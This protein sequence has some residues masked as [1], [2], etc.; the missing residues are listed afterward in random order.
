M[1]RKT[2][3]KLA[4]CQLFAGLFCLVFVIAHA[5]LDA[6]HNG[7]KYIGCLSCHQMTSTY[8]KLLPPLHH[9]PLDGDFDD[10]VANGVCWSCH[11]DSTPLVCQECHT[12]SSAPLVL[13]HSSLTTGD[14][15]HGSWT[16]ECWVCHNQHMQEQNR[17]NGS[18]YGKYIRRSINLKNIK[19]GS[20]NPL[21]GKVLPNQPYIKSVIFK[22]STGANSFADGDATINGICEVCHTA[23]SHSRNNDTLGG[24]KHFQAYVCTEC[25]D[26]TTG[27]KPGWPDHDQ[28]VEK[29]AF[30]TTCHATSVFA[31]HQVNETDSTTCKRCHQTNNNYEFTG[32]LPTVYLKDRLTKHIGKGKL[33]FPATAPARCD[34][35]HH[36]QFTEHVTDTGHNRLHDKVVLGYDSDNDG[37]GDQVLACDA[38][39]FP[40]AIQEHVTRRNFT[41]SVCHDRTG[42]GMAEVAAISTTIT[43]GMAGTKIFCDDCH[44]DDHFLTEPGTSLVKEH[45]HTPY[46]KAGDCSKCHVVGPG[47][48]G[49]HRPPCWHCHA[50]GKPGD[51]QRA[52]VNSHDQGPAI[53]ADAVQDFRICFSCHLDG[54]QGFVAGTTPLATPMHGLP[55][56]APNYSDVY[57]PY[58]YYRDSNGQWQTP[59]PLMPNYYDPYIP[60]NLEGDL[61]KWLQYP[62]FRTLNYLGPQKALSHLYE[63]YLSPPDP[64]VRVWASGLTFPLPNNNYA[65]RYQVEISYQKQDYPTV[66]I[67]MGG[68]FEIPSF[69]GTGTIGKPT[70][71]GSVNVNLN[72]EPVPTGAQWRLDGGPWRNSGDS[73]A[74][75]TDRE[76]H[77]VEF[78]PL[79]GKAEPAPVLVTVT[80]GQSAALNE[81]DTTYIDCPENPQLT[82][83]RISGDT[84][85]TFAWTSPEQEE[86]FMITGW[87]SGPVECELW[88]KSGNELVEA[89]GF[90]VNTTASGDSCRLLKTGITPAG[91]YDLLLRVNGSSCFRN[92]IDQPL[93]VTVTAAGVPSPFGQAGGKITQPFLN[94]LALPTT[95]IQ[96]FLHLTGNLYVYLDTTGTLRTF[97]IDNQGTVVP[98]IPTADLWNNAT[99]IKM[100]R[101][102]DTLIAVTYRIANTSI[103]P[104]LYEN[105][106]MSVGIEQNGAVIYKKQDYLFHNSANGHSLQPQIFPHHDN[107]SLFIVTWFGS[108]FNGLLTVQINQSGVITELDRD[109][110]TLPD[111]SVNWRGNIAHVAGDTYAYAMAQDI[112]IFQVGADGTITIPNTPGSTY[113]YAADASYA[114]MIRV[115]GDIFAVAYSR[116]PSGINEGVLETISISDS[117]VISPTINTYLF[118]PCSAVNTQLIPIS[119][120]VI[121]VYYHE[122]GSCDGQGGVNLKTIEITDDG[123]IR[124]PPLDGMELPGGGY[125][126][127][128]RLLQVEGDIFAFLLHNDQSQGVTFNGIKTYTISR[129]RDADGID[130]SADNCPNQGN[131]GQA[132]SDSDGVGDGCDICAGVADTDTDG[133]GIWDCTD[134]CPSDPANDADGDGICADVDHCPD[135]PANDGDNDGLCAGSGFQGSKTGDRDNCPTA[136]NPGQADEDCDGTGDACSSAPVY[137]PPGT[138]AATAL[139][140]TETTITWK[141]MFDGE[142]GYRIER[143]AESCSANTLGF[144]PLVTIYRHDSFSSGIDNT[145]WNQGAALQTA[146]DYTPPILVADASGSAEISWE[147]GAAKLHTKAVN[148]GDT[149]YNYSYISPK[150][151][152]GV[153]GD[154]DFDVQIDF[155]LPNGVINATQYHTY[156]RLQ[157]DF[158]NTDD[159]GNV[160]YIERKADGIGLA[161]TVNG[162]TEGGSYA[163]NDY[164]GTIRLVRKNRVLSGYVW[165]GSKWL[166]IHTHS[167]A[168]TAD[169]VPTW[170]S[171]IH[172]ARRNEPAGQDITALIDNFRY[173]EV[174]TS[175]PPVA[176]LSLAFDEA[177]WQGT[178]G[179]VKDA[180]TDGNHG[181]AY[182]D[183]TTVLDE[184]RGRVGSFDWS[185][186]T[187]DYV[188]IPGNGT[189]KDLTSTSFTF[190]AWAK[191]ADVP[192]KTQDAPP[193]NDWIYAVMTRSYPPD[194]LT[195][196]HDKKFT[197]YV[198]DTGWGQVR[199][200][201]PTQ[202]EPGSWHHLAGVVDDTA[203]TI[204]LYVDGRMRAT[205]S[206]VGKTLYNN[207]GTSP[208]LVGISNPG[209]PDWIFPFKGR[210]DDVRIFN[211]AL[212]TD[213]VTALSEDNPTFR[214]SGLAAGTT[215]CY[216]VYPVKKDS[217][218]GW[219]K[220]ASTFEVTT[221]SLAEA[222]ATTAGTATAVAIN[223]AATLHVT[224]PYASDAN[225]DNTYTV[226]YKQS[227][228]GTWTTRVADAPHAAS[229]FAVNITG[230]TAGARY[231][232]R[233]TYLDPD[234][235]NGSAQQTLTGLVAAPGI[236]C[237]QILDNGGST[238]NGVYSIDPDG[239][240]GNAPFQAYCDMTGDGGGWTLAMK[241]DGS[242]NTFQYASS[243][244]TN[245]A[246]LNPGSPGFDTTEAKLAS[247]S[248][249]PFTQIRLGMRH[250]ANELDDVDWITI[251][252][253]AASLTSLFQPGAYIATT[254]GRDN[255][256]NLLEGVNSQPNC[257][258]EGFNTQQYMSKMR[259]GLAMN[260]EADC[261]TC[262]R[263]LGFG[264]DPAGHPWGVWAVVGGGYPGVNTQAYGWIM[265]R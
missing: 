11:R 264:N 158:P 13:T 196:A 32:T 109:M 192:P 204:S 203:K 225:A 223:D 174:G 121:G 170:F 154:R 159:K 150:R 51:P 47:E 81:A 69:D 116:N 25:H 256:L 119:D 100:V 125:A 152:A 164:S 178:P 181:M 41:C 251:N 260:Q 102:S 33:V 63:I 80:N 161:I 74:A 27:F 148:T 67:S 9:T 173:N 206:Y 128:R 216:R 199:A 95:G 38:C 104:T 182:G 187:N 142:D 265:V 224:M 103:T 85:V 232:V 111:K 207:Y 252:Q 92:T 227:V 257:N 163:L 177:N 77:L 108:G 211:R 202:Y 43:N 120:N 234:G 172:H 79:A 68:N 233:V 130:D 209:G 156:A 185:D 140:S 151:L 30:C 175:T 262:D 245:T 98:N 176:K 247:F 240:G 197:F 221:K 186:G 110:T 238:G 44:N 31:L 123:R 49:P 71:T 2:A 153:I 117:G 10:T 184:Q 241:M 155:R 1:P 254:V 193:A 35:C 134:P 205:T 36:G 129:D 212:T 169:L 16:V 3:L 135:D 65:I 89:E 19:D 17:Y 61:P 248:T 139:S 179:E 124:V 191:P 34:D 147:N 165:D 201:D 263:I 244:W 73:I 26:H 64:D 105:H 96:D 45:H 198:Y 157:V 136:G 83:E 113:R 106:I 53:T 122:Y 93:A 145:G 91:N 18:T 168:L 137:H 144:S 229:P 166:I 90:A 94:S 28:V 82:L 146:S 5:G 210:I 167:Q 195:Y 160:I 72:P 55:G 214:D 239:V 112:Q 99:N 231:D 70:G 126:N 59:D 220:H 162:V 87:R 138:L 228:A 62:G 219:V 194:S 261:N 88:R 84:E 97:T 114:E 57:W 75:V 50:T 39:H 249:V 215:Y 14:P 200:T 213:E 171:I 78:K 107:K 37:T 40:D 24:D 217:C 230:L 237:K 20:G 250:L 242:K 183:A 101:V 143:K 115:K 22:G 12:S 222:N 253:A 131:A 118:E 133:D 190:A 189:L 52:G 7:D 4:V 23:S 56:T 42:L 255:W 21:P 235:V 60:D 48:R 66:P 58:G 29:P 226:E 86:N 236:S 218:T 15:D 208:Y 149:G 180:A 246:T 132:D 243:Y 258:K 54:G 141:D 127:T 188:S 46:S 8:P 259:I 76:N 6:P